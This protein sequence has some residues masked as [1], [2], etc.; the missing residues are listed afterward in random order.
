M[1]LMAAFST[2]TA[3][4]L[5]HGASTWLSRGSSRYTWR[6]GPL[7]DQRAVPLIRLVPVCTLARHH[8]WCVTTVLSL[9]IRTR[10]HSLKSSIDSFPIASFVP[11]TTTM[12]RTSVD[13]P[14]AV[15][16]MS[17]SRTRLLPTS[18]GTPSGA[19][20]T[21]FAIFLSSRRLRISCRC[22]MARA[23]SC[24]FDFLEASYH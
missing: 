1:L 8:P 13:T 23:T 24:L 9:E 18:S 21:L 4:D 10:V 22:S 2:D 15:R 14:P 16:T 17:M 6:I 12:L 20:T 19:R 5:C 3:M 11:P 7:C